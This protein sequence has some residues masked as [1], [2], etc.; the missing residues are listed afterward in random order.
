MWNKLSS[1]ILFTHPRITLIE[2]EVE[3]S[4]GDK[5]NYLRFDNISNVAAVICKREDGKILMQ[6]EYAY[7]PNQKLFQFPGGAINLDENFENGANRELMEES[8]IKA[9]NLQFLGKFLINNRR[10][11][12][13][14]YVY[15][16]T[17][18][19]ESYLDSDIEEEI[20]NFWF[21]KEEITAMIR[22]GKII[23]QDALAAWA[24]YLS[25]EK[26]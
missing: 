25:Q 24:I 17:G 8:K 9:N 7:P 26:N 16:G 3:L 6:R 18:L 23:E 19:E 5:T 14:V 21:S 1:K 2:D 13:M 15:I 12:A 11:D 10:S 20:E 4:N 22:E